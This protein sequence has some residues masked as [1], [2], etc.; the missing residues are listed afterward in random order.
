MTLPPRTALRVLIADDHDLVR[1][2]LATILGAQDDV[3]VVAQARDGAEAVLQARRL[4]PDVCLLD[5]RMPGLDGIAAMALLAGPDV[6]EPLAVVVITTFDL[7][8]HV[9]DAL[10]AGARGFLLKD[11]GPDL[12]V[13]AV[14]AAAAG[15][16]IIAPAVTAR[17]LSTFA[18]RGAPRPAEPLDALTEREE[19]VL[20]LLALGR[21]NTEI[22]GELYVSLSTAKAHV[23]SLMGKLGA[24]NRVECAMPTRA[25]GC[26]REVEHRTG[27]PADA[28]LPAVVEEA[29]RN[30]TYRG[31]A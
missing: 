15:D 9:H 20:A 21:T 8:E 12:L 27:G 18:S 19:Q 5:V 23:A 31:G 16:A 11:W 22:A 1:V 13:A 24:R 4:R 25:G 2:G 14:R 26:G 10:Q 6:P 29:W 7:D 17:L 3:E 28:S 30:R